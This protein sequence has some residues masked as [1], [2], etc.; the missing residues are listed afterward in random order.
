MFNQ[1]KRVALATLLI[2]FATVPG[3]SF[4]AEGLSLT[5]AEA[6]A[7]ERDPGREAL[8]AR[9][10]AMIER[11]VAVA[12]WPDPQLRFGFANLPVDSFS[13][14]QEPMTQTIVGLR[15]P[16]PTGALLDAREAGMLAMAS[17]Y[18]AEEGERER[19]VRRTV[20]EIW[21]EL[22]YWTETERTIVET[23]T[24]FTS[25]VDVTRSLYAV[26][27]SNQQDIIRAELELDRLRERALHAAQ[28]ADELRAALAEWLGTPAAGML[29]LDLP[30]W[31]TVPA[32]DALMAQIQMHP[33][34]AS[35]SARLEV[36]TASVDAAEARYR[37]SWAVDLSYG[38]RAGQDLDGTDRS[39]FTSL[40]VSLDL[41]L[42]T[43]D[44]QDR[45][46]G[47][48][49]ADRSAAHA[50]RVDVTRQLTA[51][52]DIAL[53]AWHRTSAR[54]VVY[55]EALIRQTQLQS[56]AALNAYQADVGDFADLMRAYIAILNTELERLR[57]AVDQRR[58]WVAIDYLGDLD[59]A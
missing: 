56:R 37:P 58:A 4:P 43:S 9:T 10:R 22:T 34:V 47:A 55:D 48:A 21:L 30:Q 28:R 1:C 3:Q 7:I 35:R 50:E 32:R 16:I 59:D 25:L 20:R 52:L 38:L 24:L 36:A 29:A 5:Q 6:L 13:V 41:P 33:R 49:Q 42:F 54:L 40:M 26:G 14:S 12:Q 27:R 39:D 31:R 57:L 51:E 46:R 15:Q 8:E 17:G 19:R 23:T 18:Q 2:A 11:A 44:R 45:V 53:A